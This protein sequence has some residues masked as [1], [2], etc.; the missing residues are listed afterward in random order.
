MNGS[1]EIDSAED[2][3]EV[4]ASA[5]RGWLVL[6]DVRRIGYRTSVGSCFEASP[7]LQGF[8]YFELLTRNSLVKKWVFSFVN[9]FAFEKRWGQHE[10]IMIVHTSKMRNAQRT[11]QRAAG[12]RS[13]PIKDCCMVDSRLWYLPGGWF[14]L[15]LRNTRD[16]QLFD[17]V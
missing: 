6:G 11:F 17:P 9:I 12:I 4:R 13:F 3:G 15:K 2:G 1:G 16:S 7:L 10:G 14:H 5:L 8:A